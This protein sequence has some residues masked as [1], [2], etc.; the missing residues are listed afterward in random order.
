MKELDSAGERQA[1]TITAPRASS[2]GFCID[3]ILAM[4]HAQIRGFTPQN[5]N[6]NTAKIKYLIFNF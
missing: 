5:A 1:C 3:Y 4:G 2:I 6:K